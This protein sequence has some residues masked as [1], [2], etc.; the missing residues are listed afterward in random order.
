MSILKFVLF[1]SSITLLPVQNE[2]SD[3][4]VVIIPITGEINTAQRAFIKRVTDKILAEETK[5]TLVIFEIDT[6][7]GE[8]M[9][10][11]AISD[12]ILNLKNNGMRTC[13]YIA[14]SG[15]NYT[16][17]TAW[18]AGALI[19][20]SCS[21]IFMAPATV[22]GA[23][24]PI[25]MS[26][27]G[28]KAVEGKFVSALKKKF[29][30]VAE[31]NGYS[32]HLAIAMVD[33]DYELFSVKTEN[34]ISIATRDELPQYP[35]A[36]E[37]KQ[38]TKSGEPLTLDIN[39]AIKFGMASLAKS[40]E[41]I[42]S[43]Y[44]ISK[45]KETSEKSSWSEDLVGWLTS[46][47][48]AS[49]LLMLGL[50]AIYIEFKTPGF[51]VA[52]VSGILCILVLLFGHHLAGLA[53]M[54]EILIVFAGFALLAVE[55]FVIP[56]F[57]VVGVLGI[58]FIMGGLIL[59]FQDFTIPDFSS[60]IELG[61]FL[62]ASTQVIVAFMASLLTITILVRYIKFIPL[63]RGA[64]LE[65][66][67]GMDMVQQLQEFINSTGV[68]ASDLR[69]SGKVNINGKIIDAISESD[70]ISKNEK[71]VVTKV[72]YSNIYVKKA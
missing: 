28:P 11:L 59:S 56:G 49:I 72:A 48:V 2:S 53:E 38:I 41:E 67:V 7:G 25:T 40:R 51:G 55:I 37:V 69:P 60:P 61:A 15:E 71:I 8:V 16:A 63:V 35:T 12:M 57:G 45:P 66:Q 65:Q 30:A 24:Q 47:V 58:A 39:E 43:Y 4:I 26:Q 17:G 64:L 1:A 6:P 46:P 20:M 52:G 23:A 44:N 32:K 13:A 14:P 9:S 18:S 31:D 36:T 34:K 70:Y 21:K 62:N 27:E 22:I 5:P 19:A 50:V 54:T 68:A 33:P 29:S 42:F 10:T 3:Q